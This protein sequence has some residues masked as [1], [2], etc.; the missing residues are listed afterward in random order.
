MRFSS[1]FQNKKQIESFKGKGW[2]KKL[3]NAAFQ[4]QAKPLENPCI[5]FK[6]MYPI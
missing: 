5:E 1:S 3:T 4:S 6:Y 2:Q